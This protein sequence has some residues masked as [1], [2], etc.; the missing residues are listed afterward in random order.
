MGTRLRATLRH[1][2]E[3]GTARSREKANIIRDAEVT[4]AVPQKNWATTAIRSRNS[5]QALPSDVV[6]M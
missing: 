3:P 1:T 4:D 2:F 5:A 6:Q